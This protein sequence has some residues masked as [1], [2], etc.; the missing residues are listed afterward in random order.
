M[1]WELMDRVFRSS[2]PH[3]L[4][5]V[6]LALASFGEADGTS[7]FPS[8]A[9]LAAMTGLQPRTIQ[10]HLAELRACGVILAI[11]GTKGG[12]GRATRYVVNLDALRES[13]EGERE[14]HD[15]PFGHGEELQ[16]HEKRQHQSQ[17]EQPASPF[18][19]DEGSDAAQ[20]RE[21]A[22]SQKGAADATKGAAR[23]SRSVSDPSV[24]QQNTEPPIRRSIQWEP[25]SGQE[26]VSDLPE[27]VCDHE[28]RSSH[29]SDRNGARPDR[30]HQ[31]SGQPGST[32]LHDGE[33]VEGDERGSER[34]RVE[35]GVGSSTNSASHDGRESGQ[36]SAEVGSFVSTKSVADGLIEKLR[37]AGDPLGE[38]W[39]R[40]R[41]RRRRAG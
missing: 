33:R 16:A 8:K 4:R 12:R 10:T 31:D 32:C 23:I 14:S 15:A 11:G 2:L 36:K 19:P 22:S 38:L 30:D 17:R 18:G 6:A 37:Q 13:G 39:L 7:I 29:E 20:E 35:S 21:Q 26:S 25:K 41:E 5:L 34:L 24:I 40:Q 3:H 9:T 27:V 28:G 1:G